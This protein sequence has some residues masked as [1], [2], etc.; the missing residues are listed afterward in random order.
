[1]STQ[2]RNTALLQGKPDI[3]CSIKLEFWMKAFKLV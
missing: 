2:L 3:P 1:L